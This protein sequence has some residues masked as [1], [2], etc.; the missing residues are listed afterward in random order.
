MGSLRSEKYNIIL[1]ILLFAI[2]ILAIDLSYYFISNI[3]YE[4]SIKNQKKEAIHEAETLAVEGNFSIEFAMHF[5]DFYK[6]I[7]KMLK[8][9]IK[10]L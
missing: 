6:E 8:T 7:L 5:Q 9:M 2:P 4:L 10:L 3:N 1:I